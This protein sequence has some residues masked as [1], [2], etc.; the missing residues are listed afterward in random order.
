MKVFIYHWSFQDATSPTNDDDKEL[1][2]R[3]YGVNENQETVCLHIRNFYPWMC[4]EIYSRYFTD[5]TPYKNVLKNKIMDYYNHIEKPFHILFKKKLY[6]SA[7][8]EYRQPVLKLRFSSITARKQCMYRLQN[9]KDSLGG[10]RIELLCHEHEASPFLQLLCQQD[11]QACG[12]IEFDGQFITERRRCTSLKH[13]YS[14]DLSKIKAVGERSDVPRLTCMSFDLEV[15]SSDHRRMPDPDCIKDV[16]FQISCV[17][18]HQD[19]SITTHLLTLG[20]VTQNELRSDV[21]EYESEKDL[22]MGFRDFI[23]KYNPHIIIGYNIF[24]F[25][26]PYS[27]KRAQKLGVWKEWSVLG[28]TKE[29]SPLK[30]VSWSSSAYSYQEFHYLE[31][32]G[33]VWIDLLPIVKRDY[34]FSNYRLKTVSTFFLGETKDP[35]T[36]LDI[37][38][39]YE[40]GVR[41]KNGRRSLTR[42]A[43]YCVQDSMLVLKLFQKLEVWI[44]LVEMAKICNVPVMSLFVQGQQI[45]TFSQ[46]Y[47]KCQQDGILVQS[48]RSLTPDIHDLL[49]QSKYT[50]A[51][52]FPPNAGLYEWVVPYD[53]SSLY[54]TT[55]MAY[56]IDYSTLVTDESIPDEKCHV[57][58]WEDHIGC[59]HDNEKTT[60]RSKSPLCKHHKYRFLK[61]PE[62]VI[63]N[64]LKTLLQQRAVTR[65]RLK[66]VDDP[67]MSVVLEKRQLAYKLSANSMY[68]GMGVQKG[69]LPFMIGAMAT[70]AM[71]RMSIQKAAEY[72]QRV[73]NGQLIYGDSVT[74]DTVVYIKQFKYHRDIIEV[75]KICD[76]FTRFKSDPYER[77]KPWDSSMTEKEQ[78]VPL[79]DHSLQ[80][81]SRSGWASIVRIIRHKTSKCVFRIMTTSGMVQVTEDHSLLTCTNECVSPRMLYEEYLKKRRLPLLMNIDSVLLKNDSE[82]IRSKSASEE[83]YW[84]R[85]G[86][87]LVFDDSNDPVFTGFLYLLFKRDFP[88]LVFINR[89]KIDLDN[90]NKIPQGKILCIEEIDPVL[91]DYVYDIETEDGSFHCGIGGL[92]VKNTDSIYCHFSD[93]KDSK[94][95][96]NFAKNMEKKFCSL[97]PSPMKLVFEE[98]LYRRFLI[99]TKKRYMALTC[100]SDGKIDEKLTIR[101]VLLAR[102]DNCKWVRDVYE[103]ITRSIM[104][105]A[106]FQSCLDAL[107]NIFYKLFSFHPDS[108]S[109]NLFVVSKLVGKDYKVRPLPHDDQKKLERRLNELKIKHPHITIQDVDTRWNPLL[110]HEVNDTKNIPDWLREYI[111]RT[112]PAHVQLAQKMSRRGQPVNAGSRIEFLIIQHPL[113][114]A[115]LHDKIEDPMYFSKHCDLLRL[116]RV[117]YATALCKPMDQLLQTAFHHDQAC[118]RLLEYHLSYQKCVNEFKDRFVYQKIIYR[119]DDNKTEDV[120]DYMLKVRLESKKK[121]TGRQKK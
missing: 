113:D 71:G 43:K 37:F 88:N 49:S 18:Q 95:L 53:F 111:D 5:W 26:I 31:T 96:W 65:Q 41:D 91:E 84:S 106:S 66:E 32:E 93:C 4:V 30:E 107:T 61:E 83:N 44:G 79:K 47:R 40:D 46:V 13:E 116:D 82:V 48:Y 27:A 73:Y 118:S 77:F 7:Q 50:G 70:T 75:L 58:E 55:I 39:A 22:L 36:A 81:M 80:I 78:A 24:G 86:S 21:M 8:N 72:V 87:L 16:I 19:G 2:I 54:P 62:G 45:K 112:K 15:Y 25:D 92:I 1:M 68:G 108:S 119:D 74:G 6:L 42:C 100:K 12:W 34:K 94:T 109:P 121:T 85:Q 10:K 89:Y 63:P 52:V 110:Q 117:Y 101:G 97:F 33:R 102:R 98:K 105:H 28:I 38:K 114:K 64:L 90:E 35:L 11:L 20:H 76:L 14:V 69:Y 17:I 23:N 67:T 3:A 115:K 51:Y 9:K 59:E 60:A 56:N 99:L 104:M 57:M 120:Y 29:S 103:N